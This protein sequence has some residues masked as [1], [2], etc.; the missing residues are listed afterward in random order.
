[1]TQVAPEA[2]RTRTRTIGIL[3]VL[4][5]GTCFATATVAGGMA[6][7]EGADQEGVVLSRLAL[8]ALVLWGVVLL[9][10]LP[11]AVP[12]VRRPALAWMALLS[13]GVGVLLF[14]AVGRIGAPT[15]TLL[16]YVHP[17]LVAFI[18]V[19][20]RRERLTVGKSA[21]LAVGLTGVL[22]VLWTP[23]DRLDPTGVVLAL[24]GALAL[25]LYVVAA[26]TGA[27]GIPPAVVGAVVLTGAT[28]AYLPVVAA[29]G[30]P[31]AGAAAGGAW[32]AA[33]GVATGA[34]IAIFLAA[35]ARLGPIRASIGATVEPVMAV[36][37][38]ALLL[39]D[40]L[41]P[42]QLGGAA[43]VIGAVAILPLTKG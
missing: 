9:R 13:T 38:S 30:V 1:M 32:L 35:L 39:G 34:A 22:L 5:A 3:L 11:V 28:A 7:R 29:V 31:E 6:L 43:L 21:A 36:I 15:A 25:A 27:R 12:R 4:L 16:L 19:L 40:V 23:V 2:S 17:A 14:G 37:L 42:A 33:V 20:L 18:S 41:A 24:G 8:G 10:R 26:Q